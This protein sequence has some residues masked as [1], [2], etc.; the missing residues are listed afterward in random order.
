MEDAYFKHRSMN[1][2]FSEIS[3]IF[4]VSLFHSTQINESFNQ[5]RDACFC[6]MDDPDLDYDF[7]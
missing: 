4:Q 2:D 1:L 7:M 6:P 3:A 5:A